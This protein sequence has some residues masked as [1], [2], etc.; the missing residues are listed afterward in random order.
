MGPRV[1]FEY[2]PSEAKTLI[3]VIEAAVAVSIAATLAALVYGREPARL[4]G[5]SAVEAGR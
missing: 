3:L 1:A 5:T 2:P 4:Q